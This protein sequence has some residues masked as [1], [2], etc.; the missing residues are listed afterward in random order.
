M[1]KNFFPILKKARELDYRLAV[2]NLESMP[3]FG[4]FSVGLQRNPIFKFFK[5]LIRGKESISSTFKNHKE[6]GLPIADYILVTGEY[7]EYASHPMV[8]RSRTE[9]IRCHSFD[10][11]ACRALEKVDLVKLPENYVVFLDEY[12]LFTQNI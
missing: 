9:V 11:E 4:R 3:P 10:Y 12:R 1:T 6:L 2:L 8:V 5:R 7:S